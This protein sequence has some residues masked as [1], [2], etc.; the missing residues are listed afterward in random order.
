MLIYRIDYDDPQVGACI[1]WASTRPESIRR[2]D[3]IK[4]QNPAAR[5]FDITK[6]Q[7]PDG[8]RGLAEWLNS[9]SFSRTDN[10]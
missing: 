5:N 1:A 9:C 6:L 4:A 3:E 2:I 7:I 10:G 8:R